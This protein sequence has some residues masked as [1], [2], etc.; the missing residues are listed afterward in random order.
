[1]QSPP[2]S[3]TSTPRPDKRRKTGDV[4]PRN[5][6]GDSVE[7]VESEQHSENNN[8]LEHS[9]TVIRVE[10]VDETEKNV[11]TEAVAAASTSGVGA[12]RCTVHTNPDWLP[13]LI[14][15]FKEEI[16]HPLSKSVIEAVENNTVIEDKTTKR[17]I[18]MAIK[19]SIAKKL[20]DIFGG[21]SRPTISEVR[22][23]VTEL[24]FTYPAL[25][26]DDTSLGYGFGGVEG[27]EELASH[28]LDKVRKT[29]GRAL[30]KKGPS[31][32]KDSSSSSTPG[33]GMKKIYGV[34]DIKF[35]AKTS[36]DEE[37]VAKIGK[38]NDQSLTFDEREKIYSEHREALQGEFRGSKKSIANQCRGFWLDARHVEN[39]FRYL[40][41]DAGSFTEPVKVNLAKQLNI[42]EL[43][44]RHINNDVE[45]AEKFANIERKCEVEFN[46]S[47]TFKHISVMRMLGDELDDDGSV[48]VRLEEDGPAKVDGPHLLAVCVNE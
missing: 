28:I 46:G 5:L 27:N 24:Q 29:D 33:G 30:V 48:L 42:M 18:R 9:E 35:F 45:F 3:K 16:I 36:R 15:N 13:N 14:R 20:V 31:V 17:E 1:M 22:K 25:F 10:V 32:A 39:H 6:D 26:R 4:N 23:I 7:M 43:V 47:T 11:E 21:V 37:V 19:N 44:L 34:N 41:N 12:T 2:V 8:V 40:S 38:A